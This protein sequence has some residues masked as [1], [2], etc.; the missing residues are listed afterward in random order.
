[1]MDH[2][3]SGQQAI[4]PSAPSSPVIAGR[5][6]HADDAVPLPLDDQ[7]SEF[8]PDPGP[9][10]SHLGRALMVA[11]VAGGVALVFWP[12]QETVR[13]AGS[14]RPTG[15]NTLIQSEMGGTVLSV[16]FRPNQSVRAGAVLALLD[17]APLRQERQQLL[18]ELSALN[19]QAG[20]ARQQQQ[21]LQA[22]ADSLHSL[23]A[24]LTES[25]RRQV[26]QVRASLGFDRSELER[27]RS[28]LASGAVARNLVEE[29]L[30][31]SRVSEAE[32]LK[33]E[34]GVAEQQ[35]RGWNELARLRQ[36]ASQ[37]RSAADDLSKQVFQRQVRLQQ[38]ERAISRSVLRAPLAG[39]VVSTALHHPGQV[40]RAG[41]VV[42]TLAPLN[43][44]LEV[45]LQV[46]SR[47][48]SQLR[49][50]QQATLRVSACPTPEYGV[51]PA[52]LQSL[53]ADTL[54]GAGSARDGGYQALLQPERRA[55]QGRQGQCLLRQGMDVVG[56]IVTR[57][58]TVLAFLLNKLHLDAI[59]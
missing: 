9:W 59:W 20:L 28:L 3:S 21:S 58:T 17:T 32:L 26:D 53:S 35:A 24:A 6:A 34:Q 15:E 45:K 5:P 47:D 14:L 13:A 43:Q 2:P 55:L 41:E 1:M 51:L 44:Q 18:N 57:R 54:P 56:D 16:Q 46:P 36:N 33:A 8:L 19:R 7:C 10:A 52:R 22:Q 31:R 42:A 23:T 29:K 49:P 27:Y 11:V 50:G 30:A 4:I 40:L 25:S 12:L 37:A 39:S 38:L 48:I